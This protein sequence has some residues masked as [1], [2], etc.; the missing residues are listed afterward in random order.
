M[1]LVALTVSCNRPR[2][3]PSVTFTTIPPMAAGGPDKVAPI[4]GRVTGAP[5]GSRIV[6]FAKS[7]VGV[8]WVQPLSAEPFTPIAADGSWK[9][10]IHLGVEYAA[11]LVDPAYQPPPTAERLPDP[12]GVIIARVTAAGTGTLALPT[13]R[14]LSFSGYDW[15]VRQIPSDRGGANRYDPDNAWVDSEGL[16]HLRLRQRD[17]EW[18]SAEVILTRSLGYGT[19]AFVVRDVSQLDPAAAMGMLTWDDLAAAQ[20]HRELDIEISQWGDRSIANAQFVVQ[21]YGTPGNLQ[22]IATPAGSQT[23]G[24]TWRPNEVA[25][26]AGASSWTYTGT[27]IPPP[28]ASVHM[29]LWLDAGRPPTDGK[30]VDVVVSGF[31]YAP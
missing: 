7:N 23:L 13:A 26:T 14:H 20:N 9:S 18:T 3:P 27:S 22:R 19:Y 11:L 29:N 17:G 30:P 25:F 21:P 16:L 12:G 1:C 15:E 8:W 5:D 2:Q 4:A 10:T 28:P 24:F 6:I 31:S